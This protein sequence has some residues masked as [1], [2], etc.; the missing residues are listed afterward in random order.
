MSNKYGAGVTHLGAQPLLK[1]TLGDT[2]E[3]QLVAVSTHVWQNAVSE[4]HNEQ[5]GF[6]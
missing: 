3:M 5:T 6:Q 2:H 1:K 4:L